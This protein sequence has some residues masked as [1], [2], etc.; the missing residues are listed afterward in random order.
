MDDKILKFVIIVLANIPLAYFVL[1]WIFKK[2]IMFTISFW[3]VLLMVLIS[4]TS[5]TVGKVGLYAAY[6]FAP[7][8]FIVGVLVFVAINKVLRKPLDDSI[9]KIEKMSEGDLNIDIAMSDNKNELGILNNSLFNLVKSMIKIVKVIKQNSEELFVSS[10]HIND[11]A[12]NL[13]Q[14]SS[15]QA[16][17]IETISS[18]MEEI[19]TKIKQNA[20]DSQVISTRAMRT[21]E[22]MLEVKKDSHSA[23]KGNTLIN[24]KI[25]II[26]DITFQTNIL[27]L[28]AAVEAARAGE[29][30]KGFSVVASEVQKLA[31]LSKNAA[32]EIISLSKNTKVLSDKAENSLSTIIPEIEEV[33]KLF[34]NIAESSINQNLATVQANEAIRQLNNVAQRNAATSEELSGLS[35]D[36]HSKAKQ[37]KNSIA[38]FKLK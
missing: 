25:T 10:N 31:E 29:F 8:N 32:E 13:S 21:Q 1:R 17:S 36:M 24:E 26:N 33:A 28:N 22:D 15:E 16:A 2:S 9:K 20:N 4:L 23:V 19:S 3:L 18:T 27:A 34:K 35:E 11:F 5:Y 7:I 30:G 14:N 6:I 12:L 38:Y 37:L